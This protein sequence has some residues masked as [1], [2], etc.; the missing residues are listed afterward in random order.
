MQQLFK[1]YSDIL[2][3]RSGPDVLPA[4]SFLLHFTF[5]AYC[6]TNLLALLIVGSLQEQTATALFAVL[7]D[8]LLLCIWFGVLLGAA[9]FPGRLRQVL[10]AALGCGALVALYMLPLVALMQLVPR[11]Q[12]LAVLAYFVLLIWYAAALGH[13]V[14]RGM[15]VHALVGL[16]FGVFYIIASFLIVGALFPL[17]T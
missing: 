12:S 11:V 3:R 4:S 7:F 1:A 8:A 2:L 5:L 13:I 14:S 16:G 17:G 15:E 9:G 10:S 6:V